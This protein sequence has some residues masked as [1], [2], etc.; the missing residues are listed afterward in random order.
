MHW[1]TYV[2]SLLAAGI[3]SGFAS[4]LFGVGGGIVRI[5][6]FLYLF[7]VFGVHASVVMHLSAGTS[8]TL[9]IPSSISASRAQYKA[10]NIDLSFLRTWIP[11]L[12]LGVILGLIVMRYVS[13]R[14][15]IQIFAFLILAVSVQMFFTTKD[16]KLADQVPGRLVRGVIASIIGCLS[17]MVG[18]T[19]GSF[20]TPALTAFGYSIH[21]SIAIA[22]AGGFFISVIGA[23]GSV[24]NGIHVAG[25]PEFSL[26]YVDL[27]S[28]VVMAPAVLLAAP[29]GVRLANRLSQDRLR[30]VFAVFLFIVSLDML[31][32]LYF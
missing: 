8:L 32:D 26:G 4:G 25:R 10:G 16:F 30:R 27:T 15:L 6:L 18:L 31:F 1:I 12:V 13:S 9:A 24:F 29:Y 19:G 3:V 28:V 17:T 11:A 22:T 14:F 23:A 7:P 20:T 2:L 5:P 21:R